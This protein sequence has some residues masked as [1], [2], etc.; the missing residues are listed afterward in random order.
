[1]RS[2]AS[3][4]IIRFPPRPAAQQAG[5]ARLALALE[6]LRQSLAEQATAI[7]QWR[8]GLDQLR[9]RIS[10][11]DASTAALQARLGDVRS[12]VIAIHSEAVR[13]VRWAEAERG[14][15]QRGQ[16]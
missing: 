7:A 5:T 3:A 9:E 1:M 15:V 2:E 13:L 11:L 6:R 10:S 4:A 14:Q 12:G 8:S 16:V